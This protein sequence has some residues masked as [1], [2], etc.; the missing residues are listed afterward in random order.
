MVLCISKLLSK[1]HADTSELVEYRALLNC[2][3]G[4]L[5][6]QSCVEGIA[7]LAQGCPPAGI[8]T[9]GGTNTIFF[10]Y[11][12]QLPPGRSATYLRLVVSDRP[13]KPNHIESDPGDVSTQAS[14]L[15]TA[16]VLFNNVLSTPNACFMT[17][18]IKDFYLYTPME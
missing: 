12:S 14:S 15:L 3:D 17:I 5:W 18:N 10:I 1:P 4:P 8:P 9:T 6:E 7:R 2:S 11:P 13:Q 16:K